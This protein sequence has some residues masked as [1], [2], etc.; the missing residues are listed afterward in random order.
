MGDWVLIDIPGSIVESLKRA[1][2]IE[3][4]SV[5]PGAQLIDVPWMLAT[6]LQ[7]FIN[8]SGE[9]NEH[10]T[11]DRSWNVTRLL[12]S[13]I[14]MSECFFIVS[15]MLPRETSS[16]TSLHGSNRSIVLFWSCNKELLKPG[17]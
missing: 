3:V 6:K 5:L 1:A 9:I 11:I 17:H 10:P 7:W 8:A 4:A 12:F 13:Q 14:P 16:G 15:T 2:N